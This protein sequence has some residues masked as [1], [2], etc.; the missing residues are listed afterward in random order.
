MAAASMMPS[1]SWQGQAEPASLNY[2]QECGHFS[3][4]LSPVPERASSP[5][6]TVYHTFHIG[7]FKSQKENQSLKLALLFS[8]MKEGYQVHSKTRCKINMRHVLIQRAFTPPRKMFHF[9]CTGTG[10]TPTGKPG[11]LSAGAIRAIPGKSLQQ[12]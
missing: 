10:Y 4:N 11:P 5:T 2:Y 12:L 7:S 6:K 1:P 3:C 8:F 9:F